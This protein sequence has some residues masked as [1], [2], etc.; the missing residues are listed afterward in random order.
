MTGTEQERMMNRTVILPGSNPPVAPKSLW[1]GATAAAFLVITMAACSTQSVDR[2][3]DHAV[4]ATAPATG[5]ADGSDQADHNCRIVLRSM[6]RTKDASGQPIQTCDDEGCHW[7]WEAR[8]D[9]ASDLLLRRIALLYHRTSDPV[10]WEAPAEV[11]GVGGAG[12]TR[13]RVLVTQHVPGPGDDD[14]IEAIPLLLQDDNDRLFDHNIVEGDLDS[15]RLEAY[16]GY[17]V[18]T[19]TKVCSHRPDT[20]GLI[21][22]SDWS[23]YD[24]NHDLQAGGKVAIKYDLDRMTQCRGTHNGYPAWLI[25][26]TIQFLPG[27]Q[28]K[29]SPV[30]AFR[31]DRGT[32]ID[33]AYPIPFEVDVPQDATEAVVWFHNTAASG[34]FCE[35]WDSNYNK[36]YHFAVLPAKGTDPCENV[37]LWK[38]REHEAQPFCPAYQV[39]ENQDA[40]D[41]A[42]YLDA[43][44]DVQT[45][46]YGIPESWLEATLVARSDQGQVLGAGMYVE[47]LDRSDATQKSTWSFG[48]ADPSGTWHTGFQYVETGYPITGSEER[49]V[50]AFAFFADVRRANG[51]VVR[52]WQSRGGANYHWDDAFGLPTTRQYIAY[53]HVEQANQSSQVFENTWSCR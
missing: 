11:M 46:H 20:A 22:G 27:G 35:A 53:G 36:N 14:A 31:N 10:W 38:G 43:I 1:A 19:N 17:R 30:M 9:V 50:T 42:L 13:F 12:F 41:C 2:N 25:R 51:T 18:Y 32:P 52:V 5:K 24:E 29:T 16:S 8:I 40:A 15:Y 37:L 6:E 39:N 21:F 26:A 7:T 33:E 47:A 48:Y 45:G 49:R 4:Q 44:Q 3:T 28:T 34:G 23:A